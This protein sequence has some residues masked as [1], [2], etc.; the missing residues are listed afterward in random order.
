MGLKIQ[1]FILSSNNVMLLLNMML[2]WMESGRAALSCEPRNE[3]TQY[4]H[5][6]ATENL[7]IPLISSS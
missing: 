6:S 4:F 2:Y 7:D 3:Y 5:P 1:L